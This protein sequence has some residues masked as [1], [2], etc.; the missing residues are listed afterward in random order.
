[1]LHFA[2][3][4]KKVKRA[5]GLICLCTE[6]FALP[7]PQEP[8]IMTPRIAQLEVSASQGLFREIVSLNDIERVK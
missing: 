8:T 7:L 4:T 3:A 6:A 2:A 1:M 5:L